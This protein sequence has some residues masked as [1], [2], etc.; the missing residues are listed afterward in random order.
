MSQLS[1][2]QAPQYKLTDNTF[3]VENAR[4]YWLFIQFSHNEA[5]FTVYDTQQDRYIALHTAVLDIPVDDE[6]FATW[7][8]DYTNTHEHIL[9]RNYAKVSMICTY[10]QATL[11]PAALYSKG[12]EQEYLRFH[13]PQTPQA[14]I[15]SDY[16]KHADAYCVFA[17]TEYLDTAVKAVFP[18]AQFVQPSQ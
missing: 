2:L 4:Q 14:G 6:H 5:A 13:F 15:Y 1:Q 16:I 10:P 9:A 12:Q 3:E 7:F 17:I 18:H 11:I 8:K